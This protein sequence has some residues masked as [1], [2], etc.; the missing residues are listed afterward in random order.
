MKIPNTIFVKHCPN[1]SPER[2][3]FLIKYLE[4]RVPIKDVR[5]EED[6]IIH[7]YLSIGL[8]IN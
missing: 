3:T 7:I 2:K 6:Y 1:L 8:I 4:E 5:W